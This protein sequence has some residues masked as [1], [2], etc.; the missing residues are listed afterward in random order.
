MN[1]DLTKLVTNIV[2]SINIDI[3]VDIPKNMYENSRVR[4]LK[5]TLFKGKI[6]KNYDGNYV[7][8]G[9]LEGIMILDDDITLEDVDYKFTTNI[10]EE[11]N[12]Y[13]QN[14]ENNLKIIQNSL[15][16]TEFLWQNILVE[17]PLKVISDKNKNLKLEGNGWRLIT[18]KDID[19]NT[20]N[21]NNSPFNE[22]K[23]KLNKREE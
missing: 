16:I 20:D 15:D 12:E 17:I 11:F 1:I 4:N 14:L 7:I 3:A 21:S 22:L 13:E 9:I 19:N 8:E 2:D 5:N 6:T 18:E 10:Y 23:E